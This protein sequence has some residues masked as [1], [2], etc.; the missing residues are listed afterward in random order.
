MAL[1]VATAAEQAS[2]LLQGRLKLWRTAAARHAVVPQV[3]NVEEKVSGLLRGRLKQSSWQA[4]A[5][6]PAVVLQVVTV[7]ESAAAACR[8]WRERRLQQ[9]CILLSHGR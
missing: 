4:A 2:G 3:V 1:R 9:T 6:L 7:A 5:A 8:P